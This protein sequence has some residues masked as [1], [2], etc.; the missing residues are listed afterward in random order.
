MRIV[1]ARLFVR[2]DP[3][4]CRGVTPLRFSLSF[5][6]GLFVSA[7][8]PHFVSG[9]LPCAF[10]YLFSAISAPLRCNFGRMAPSFENTTALNARI[11]KDPSPA[12]LSGMNDPGPPHSA[13]AES[14]IF[15]K[16]SG[17]P[18]F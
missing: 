15:L 4:G 14:S 2:A 12:V 18:L 17:G 9:Q 16:A 10:P 5:L 7:A 8:I 6:R 13:S 1:R 11:L 3:V